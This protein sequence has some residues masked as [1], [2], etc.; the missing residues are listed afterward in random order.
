MEPCLPH[1]GKK[2]HGFQGHG[3]P[4]RVG[5]RDDQKV[6]VLSQ[7][8]VN[9]HGLF[10]GKK[11]MAAFAD[12]YVPGSVKKRPCGILLKGQGRL[13]KGEIQ[14]GHDPLILCKLPRSEERRTLFPYTTLFRF[15]RASC[16]ERV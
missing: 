5:P 10:D 14:E 1:E 13:G 4:S 7:A 2:P 6:K 3:F 9:G 12:V 11:G 15:G 16:R 8:D